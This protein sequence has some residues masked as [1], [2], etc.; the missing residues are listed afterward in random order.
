M[1]QNGRVWLSRTEWSSWLILTPSTR[2]LE[3]LDFPTALRPLDAR[4]EMVV[5]VSED[6]FG[7]Q[8]LVVGSM[9]RID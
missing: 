9:A 1:D 4:D 6:D 2:T 8:Q 7:V 5:M 3:L